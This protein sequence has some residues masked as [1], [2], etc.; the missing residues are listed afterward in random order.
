MVQNTRDPVRAQRSEAVTEN[1][2]TSVMS[3]CKFGEL[4]KSLL[5][6][7]QSPNDAARAAALSKILV[8]RE[9]PQALYSVS[10]S[11]PKNYFRPRR[12]KK[13]CSVARSL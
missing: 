6:L 5:F 11:T 1:S 12:N 3:V 4:G 13:E 2:L 8:A 9:A 7:A 10:C